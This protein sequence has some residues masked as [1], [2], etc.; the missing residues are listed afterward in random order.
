VSQASSDGHQ[1]WKVRAL[2]S[3]QDRKTPAPGYAMVPTRRGGEVG[4]ERRWMRLCP[5]ISE[6]GRLG[7]QSSSAA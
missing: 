5:C 1:N 7:N 4:V 3:R 2:E 6:G